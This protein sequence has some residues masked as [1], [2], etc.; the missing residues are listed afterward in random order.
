[1]RCVVADNPLC[2]PFQRITGFG[3]L[4]TQSRFRIDADL[5][6]YLHRPTAQFCKVALH[7]LTPNFLIQTF[8]LQILHI[9]ARHPRQWA[10]EILGSRTYTGPMIATSNTPDFQHQQMRAGCSHQSSKIDALKF[11]K[12]WLEDPAKM[13]EAWEISG[14]MILGGFGSPDRAGAAPT[15]A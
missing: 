6:C 11:V 13:A 14:K 4:D 8:H 15:P 2:Q 12:E 1:V 7:S 10:G 3:G 9:A 5:D